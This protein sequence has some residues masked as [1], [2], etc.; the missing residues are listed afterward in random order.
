M[1][2][3]PHFLARSAAVAG[4]SE[5]SA[6]RPPSGGRCAP[7]FFGGVEAPPLGEVG[8]VRLK[9][10]PDEIA[11]KWW[12]R[13]R[14]SVGACAVGCDVLPRRFLAG[15]STSRV[16]AQ[17]DRK[18]QIPRGARDD[19][20]GKRFARS[21]EQGG[22][23]ERW[24]LGAYELRWICAVRKRWQ[25]RRTPKEAEKRRGFWAVWGATI[26]A[27]EPIYFVD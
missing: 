27:R 18:Q 25:S 26:R 9:A 20:P 10:C 22:G 5:G 4:W 24:S 15:R 11:R 12:L 17:S 7:M 13:L 1:T 6:K 16:N 14:P 8:L 19:G 23:E 3:P 2:T 21:A